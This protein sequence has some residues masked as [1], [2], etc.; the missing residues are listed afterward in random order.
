VLLIGNSLEKID[1]IERKSIQAIVTSP[2]YWGLRDYKADG[3]LGEELVPEDFVKNLT[4]LFNKSKR[5]LKDDGTLW[6]NIG[7]TYFGAKGG[8]WEGGNSITNDSTGGNYR[9]QRKAPPKHSRLKTKDLTGIPWMLAFSL[10]KDGWYLRQDIIWH[11]PN[12]MPE[13]VKDRCVKSHEHIFLLTLHPRYYFDYEAIQEKA[14]YIGDNRASRGD[15]RR[16]EPLAASMAAD[17][18]PTSEFRNKRDVWS[19]NTAQSGEAHFAVFPEKIPELCIK[20]GTKEGDV[21][22]DPFMGSGTTANVAKRLGR[23]WVGIELNADY[24]RF[25]NTKTAQEELF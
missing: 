8:H 16:D 5:V 9:M 12:P 10:Q 15:S 20:A 3:Q 11:K 2:P 22:L 24:A 1:E 18:K 6:L 4:T 25:I 7:D 23:K 21:V 14:V 13:A 17:S 19:I